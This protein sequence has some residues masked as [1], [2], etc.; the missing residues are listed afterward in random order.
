[1]V[2]EGICLCCRSLWLVKASVCTVSVDGR[3]LSVL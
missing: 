3:H 2:G 1:M